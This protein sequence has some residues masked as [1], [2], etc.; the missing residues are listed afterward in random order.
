VVRREASREHVAEGAERLQGAAGARVRG[1]EGVEGG[2][3]G[4]G[5]HA[6][7]PER[8]ATPVVESKGNWLF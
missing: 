6:G 7:R 5:W 2:E 8:L 1:D 4:G 3:R